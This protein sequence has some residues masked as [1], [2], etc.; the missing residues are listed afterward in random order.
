MSVILK[1]KEFMKRIK[2]VIQQIIFKFPLE[3]INIF[4]IL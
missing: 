1:R 3:N 4:Y 2:D